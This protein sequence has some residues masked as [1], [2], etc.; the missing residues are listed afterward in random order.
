MNVSRRVLLGGTAA[1]VGFGTFTGY[2]LLAPISDPEGAIAHFTASHVP[3]V[4]AGDEVV[5]TFSTAAVPEMQNLFGTNF[6]AHVAI[7]ANPALKALLPEDEAIA[8]S[9]FER[10][11]ITLF[12][13]STDLL[14]RPDHTT[15]VSFLTFAD[16]YT[17]GCSNPFAQ[18]G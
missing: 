18:L 4:K 1:V 13:R 3:H 17:A 14:L 2:R 15:P 10:T 5:R 7:L 11:I 6:K 12:V 16:P 9:N 8:Q